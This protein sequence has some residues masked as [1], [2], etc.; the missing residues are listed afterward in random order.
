MNTTLI[1]NDLIGLKDKALAALILTGLPDEYEITVKTLVST[2]QV[3]VSSV[4][5]NLIEE[6][7]KAIRATDGVPS[8][9]AEDCNPLDWWKHHKQDYPHIYPLARHYLGL[10]PTEVPSERMFSVGGNTCTK[11]RS[12]LLT[13]HVKE[14]IYIHDNYDVLMRLSKLYNLK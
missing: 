7:E 3:K 8:G 11:K 12:R 10:A 6:S 13:D 9:S 1:K 14:M 2:N 5:L 4:K